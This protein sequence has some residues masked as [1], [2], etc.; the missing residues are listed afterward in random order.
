MYSCHGFKISETK[1]VFLN[2]IV[3]MLISSVKL[4]ILTWMHSLFGGQALLVS[5]GTATSCCPILKTT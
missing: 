5:R 1:T 3:N 2:Q 4:D